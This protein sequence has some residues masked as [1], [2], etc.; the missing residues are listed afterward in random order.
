MDYFNPDI[1]TAIVG[2][3]MGRNSREGRVKVLS[4]L[5]PEDFILDRHRTIYK[6][7]IYLE[8]AGITV[9]P[10]TVADF[11]RK[12]GQ[13]E[14]VGDRSYLHACHSLSCIESQ[15]ED[16]INTAYFNSVEYKKYATV[17]KIAKSMGNGRQ[18]LDFLEFKYEELLR[19]SQKQ[20]KID[21]YEANEFIRMTFPVSSDYLEE[22]I[23]SRKS[24]T[25]I[26][27]YAKSYK[28]MFSLN[29]ALC[30]AAGKDFLGFHTPA[31]VKVLYIQEEVALQTIQSR[32]YKMMREV[33]PLP[34]NLKIVH[35][36]G[37]KLTT[38]EGFQK[39]MGIIGKAEPQVIFF[40]PLYKFHNEE[41]NSSKEMKR[42]LN[43]FDRI[44]ETYGASIVIVHH[45]GK[46]KEGVGRSQPENVRGSS[47]LFDYVDTS[48]RMVKDDKEDKA[49]SLDFTLRNA[50][51]PST[52]KLY[53]N[54]NLFFETEKPY[55][56]SYAYH[57]YS[58]GD[59][60]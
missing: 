22:G 26:S 3:M 4:S 7:I 49:V 25:L 44:I 29:M 54:N 32:I 60:V 45:H 38:K 58:P 52:M 31:P 46:R 53:L 19:Q 24:V 15:L 5:A 11:L 55:V 34:G 59:N 23:V 43:L 57:G 42:V 28:T 39:T 1:E 51:D 16:Y 14:A 56:P 6:A 33:Q 21:I 8:E 41:E 9:D 2:F 30:L 17:R 20:T 47:V 48:I 18:G 40:D 13:L 12:N 27:A 37:I 50:E 10:I 36:R 35:G